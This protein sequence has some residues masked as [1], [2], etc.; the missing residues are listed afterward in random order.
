MFQDLYSQSYDC[1]CVMFASVPQFKEFYSESSAN[2][3]G[4]ECLRFLNEI[5]SDFDE[6]RGRRYD[7]ILP[8]LHLVC[9]SNYTLFSISLMQIL[10]KPKF[11]SVEKIKTIGSTYMAAAGLRHAPQRDEQKVCL[12]CLVHQ[13]MSVITFN[14]LLQNNH[15]DVNQIL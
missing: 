3:D 9:V 2:R 5:I 14:L 11:C 1:V 12:I 8:L 7:Y 10:S 4:L 13:Q 6:V 15:C